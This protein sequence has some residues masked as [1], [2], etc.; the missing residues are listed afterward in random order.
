MPTGSG[1]ERKGGV[2]KKTTNP[3]RALK[4]TNFLG[5]VKVT[6]VHMEVCFAR[7]TLFGLKAIHFVVF[8]LSKPQLAAVVFL[9]LIAV[10]ERL[11]NRN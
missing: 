5:L 11:I 4:M 7:M 3:S 2:K 10:L 6:A 9:Y 1:Y 8:L